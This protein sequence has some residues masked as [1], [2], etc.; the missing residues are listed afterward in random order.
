MKL[1]KRYREQKYRYG[2]YLEVNLYPV[3]F[4]TRN[5]RRKSRK[6]PSRECQKRL[7]QLNAERQLARIMAANFTNDDYK[8]ELTYSPDNLPEDTER[9]KKDLKN[10]LARMSRAR[11]KQGLPPMKYIYSL[12]VGE[13]TKRI[14]FH[15]VISGGMK[16]RDI[17]KIWGKGYVDKIKPLMFDETGLRGIARYMCKQRVSADGTE[18]EAAGMKRYQCSQNCIKPQ[19][20]NNDSKYSKKKV[21]EIAEDIENRRMIE[22]KYPGYFCGE[23]KSFWNENNG[24]HY[25]SMILYRQDAELD[26][27][28]STRGSVE[29]KKRRYDKQNKSA[30][31]DRRAERKPVV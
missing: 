8:L 29:N 27:R 22:A 24:E 9:A 25:I 30:G 31:G 7:N 11:K 4:F 16:P 5:G 18:T 10:F 13:R 3:Y 26:I 12:E 21:R 19:P 20:Q 6:K 1:A 23:C 14:H 17:Q 2:D 28:S 15:M